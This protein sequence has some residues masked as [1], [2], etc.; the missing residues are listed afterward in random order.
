VRISELVSWFGSKRTFGRQYKPITYDE[1]K[2]IHLA[3]LEVPESTGMLCPSDKIMRVFEE[4]GP[5]VDRRGKVVC[6]V[7]FPCIR[8]AFSRLK[9]GYQMRC[10]NRLQYQSSHTYHFGTHCTVLEFL[11][12]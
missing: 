10:D 5:E 1:A 11:N 8:T 6:L 4:G 12:K 9:Y 3:T 2:K 7:S